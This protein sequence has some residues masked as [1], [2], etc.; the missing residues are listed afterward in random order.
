MEKFCRMEIK[1]ASRKKHGAEAFF[2]RVGR[3]YFF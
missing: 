3:R 2:F 1:A